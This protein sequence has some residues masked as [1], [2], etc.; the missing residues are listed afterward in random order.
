M[1]TTEIRKAIDD[2]KAILGAKRTMKLL[3]QGK[4][5]QVY[6]TSNVS[7]HV[8]DDIEHLCTISNVQIDTIEMTNK[9]L[10]VL[11]KRPFVVSVLSVTQ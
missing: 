7:D 8:R 2:G 11:C 5:K 3:R 6:L 10:G 1:S 9:E 4:L